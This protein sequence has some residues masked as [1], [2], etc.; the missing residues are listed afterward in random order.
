ME[1]NRKSGIPYNAWI[2][3]NVEFMTGQTPWHS[4]NINEAI[5]ILPLSSALLKAFPD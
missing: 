5:H 1:T 3:P 4:L 2:S